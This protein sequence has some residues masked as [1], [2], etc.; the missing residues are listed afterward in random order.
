M[1]GGV[2]LKAAPVVRGDS[3]AEGAEQQPPVGF[4]GNGH[5][6]QIRQ[7]IFEAKRIEPRAVEPADAA[8][9]RGDPEEPLAVLVEVFDVHPAQPVK[10]GV[11]AT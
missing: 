8:I 2:H 10:D 5:D 4:L 11:L 1:L 3:T 6:R 9:G 7:A